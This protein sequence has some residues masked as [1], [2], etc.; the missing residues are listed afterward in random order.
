MANCGGE[1]PLEVEG[2]KD[3]AGKPNVRGKGHKEGS[4]NEAMKGIRGKWSARGRG[5]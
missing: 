5:P 2:M 4:T 3:V 1:P